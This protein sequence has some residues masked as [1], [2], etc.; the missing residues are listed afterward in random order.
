MMKYKNYVATVEFDDEANVFHGEIAN[1]RDVIT[2]EGKTVNE[3]RSAFKDSVD[4]YLAF[5]DK[6]GEEPEKP[7]SGQL[8]VRLTPEQHRQIFLS[9]KEAGKSLNAW[10]VEQ[11]ARVFHA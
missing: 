10:I 1:I 3:L 8:I 7:F 6:R 4:D 2:F 11:L 5:C 9:A